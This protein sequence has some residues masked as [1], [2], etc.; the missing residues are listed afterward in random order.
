MS[1]RREQNSEI[2]KKYKSLD[3]DRLVW[4]NPDVLSRYL[5]LFFNCIVVAFIFA[6]IIWFI[7]II[8]MDVSFKLEQRKLLRSQE[9]QECKTNYEINECKPELRVPALE[10]L[11]KE[12]LTC[13]NEGN[14]A[15]GIISHSARLWAQTLAEVLNS[16]VDSISIRSLLFIL[17]SVTVTI[18]VTKFTFGSYRIYHYN[19]DNS[20]NQLT[21][22][23]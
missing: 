7:H 14:I 19:N 13:I 11:C 8:R 3:H 22:K 20:T 2:S 17:I 1:M 21:T 18:A 9:I 4:R 15:I 23:R 6:V 16:F 12:W 10:A 5:Q